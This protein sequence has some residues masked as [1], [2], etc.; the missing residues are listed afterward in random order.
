[1]RKE[2]ILWGGWLVWG[3]CLLAFIFPMH[4][5]IKCTAIL[6][7]AGSLII[8]FR[9]VIKRRANIMRLFNRNLKSLDCL[10]AKSIS[11]ANVA[12]SEDGVFVPLLVKAADTIAS[13]KM[14]KDTIISPEAKLSGKLEAQGNIVIEGQ[15]EGDIVCSHQFRV[16][17]GG[18]VTGDIH[19]QHIVIDGRVEGR[20][21]ADTVTLMKEGF[22]QGSV[23]ADQLI[24]EKGGVFFGQSEL[25]SQ[26]HGGPFHG[27][28][29]ES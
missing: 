9:Y 22:I 4:H 25:K 17:S 11:A 10:K 13:T 5:L 21:Y 2:T 28:S 3:F 18:S 26:E 19:A 27:L 8:F 12:P 15:F 16:E 23:F 24:I 1:M 7:S 14:T 29:G 6:I 20:L